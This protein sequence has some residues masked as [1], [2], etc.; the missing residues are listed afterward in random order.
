MAAAARPADSWAACRASAGA[1]HRVDCTTTT[2]DRRDAGALPDGKAAVRLRRCDAEEVPPG[3]AWG[4][5]RGAGA[6]RRC[7][8]SCCG[9]DRRCRVCTRGVRRYRG[10]TR[11]RTGLRSRR[12]GAVPARSDT[13]AGIVPSP[14]WLAGEGSGGLSRACKKNWAGDSRRICKGGKI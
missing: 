11:R 13:A 3:D 1:I 14:F 9:E 10:D 4:D 2:E 5:R 7:C 12:R 6:V 8:P